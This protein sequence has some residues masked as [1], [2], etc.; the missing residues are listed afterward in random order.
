MHTHDIRSL[1]LVVGMLFEDHALAVAVAVAVDVALE[2]AVGHASAHH[3]F[4]IG[5]SA[6]LL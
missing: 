1:R 4:Q 5:E 2:S 6:H 3:T